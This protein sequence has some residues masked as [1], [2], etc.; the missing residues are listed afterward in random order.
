L[1]LSVSQH[2]RAST[3]E[4][5]T[6]ASVNGPSS[7]CLM[8][9]TFEE[10]LTF[11]ILGAIHDFCCLYLLGYVCLRGRVAAMINKNW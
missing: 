11:V 8:A 4:A 5:L 10:D 1:Q 2:L 7:W 3:E 9:G 6:V